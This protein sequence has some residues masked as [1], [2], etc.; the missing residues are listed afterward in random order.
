MLASIPCDLFIF[1]VELLD[2][3]KSK[4]LSITD[5]FLFNI[6]AFRILLGLLKISRHILLWVYKSYFLVDYAK[7]LFAFILPALISS[8]IWMY[9][10]LCL[11]FCLKIV[12]INLKLYIYLQK[13]FPAIYPFLLLQSVVGS[14]FSSHLWAWQYINEPF[15]NQTSGN[16]SQI[17]SYD[18]ILKPT[19]AFFIAIYV[20]SCFVA[21]LLLFGS[22][23][24]IV[25]SLYRHMKQIQANTDSTMNP[26]IGPRSCPV[27]SCWL[28]EDSSIIWPTDVFVDFRNC[29]ISSLSPH[30]FIFLMGNITEDIMGILK[31]LNLDN[32]E[33]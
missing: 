5:L 33:K 11:H 1:V 21:F 14:L 4:R 30:L 29:C 18:Y 20:M 22:A 15:L 6:S 26:N 23:L 31:K 13:K 17:M 16:S 32:R 28:P 2:W 12:N 9:T 7:M 3:S 10:W 8:N 19:K 27:E 25:I 24:T